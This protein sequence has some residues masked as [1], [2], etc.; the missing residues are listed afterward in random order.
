[1]DTQAGRRPAAIMAVEA[2]IQLLLLLGHLFLLG[3]GGL[4]A[5]SFPL[6]DRWLALLQGVQVLLED[7]V[8]VDHDET[9]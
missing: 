9:R 4:V 6:E 5:P 1:M 8:T 2:E 7:S 3:G